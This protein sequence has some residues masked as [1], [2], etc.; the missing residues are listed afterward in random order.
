MDFTQYLV[1]EY[2]RFEQYSI[3][4]RKLGNTE[5]SLNEIK[6]IADELLNEAEVKPLYIASLRNKMTVPAIIC[7]FKSKQAF[8]SVMSNHTRQ[9]EITK[10]D[11][12][13]TG[14]HFDNIAETCTLH[15]HTPLFYQFTDEEMVSL[16][17]EMYTRGAVCVFTHRLDRESALRYRLFSF[18]ILE[19]KIFKEPIFRVSCTFKTDE[20][21]MLTITELFEKYSKEL[22]NLQR[23]CYRNCTI[24]AYSGKNVFTLSPNS[25]SQSFD[26]MEITKITRW[27][28]TL[29]AR[30]VMA[31]VH[32]CYDNM[33]YPTACYSIECYLDYNDDFTQ[34]LN[35]FIQHNE[36]IYIQTLR[37][38][39]LIS[40][41][42]TEYI[43]PFH[44]RLDSN[45]NSFMILKNDTEIPHL[46]PSE[47][48]HFLVKLSQLEAIKVETDKKFV[49]CEFEDANARLEAA[50]KL[51]S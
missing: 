4:L 11:F 51:L 30:S 19:D 9:N 25:I 49:K 50:V 40:Q 27:L 18:E 23:D 17:A 44:L 13:I 35:E 7:T 21:G 22:K 31:D 14:F 6:G 8:E 33:E 15:F 5:F 12:L 29:G 1:T 38:L 46:S 16:C 26:S 39:N 24:T 28:F 43:P 47:R 10:S 2:T 32:S 3:A 41:E 20:A 36:E 45:D 34:K 42:T 48:F 37:S